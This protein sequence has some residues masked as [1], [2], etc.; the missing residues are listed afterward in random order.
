[1]KEASAVD[2][3]SSSACSATPSVVEMD[4]SDAVAGNKPGS[5]AEGGMEKPT[6]VVIPPGAVTIASRG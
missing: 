4:V 3:S 6:V 2:M 5:H 1:M